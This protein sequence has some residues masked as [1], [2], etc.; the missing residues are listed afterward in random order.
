MSPFSQGDL[1]ELKNDLPVSLFP[2]TD[3]PFA[4]LMV[5][6]ATLDTRLLILRSSVDTAEHFEI[7]R[8]GSRQIQVLL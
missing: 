5:M 6:N 8:N 2:R 4:K 3:K 7:L 1:Q